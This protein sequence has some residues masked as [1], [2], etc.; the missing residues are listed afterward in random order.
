MDKIVGV[1]F[2]TE[3]QLKYYLIGNFN[4]NKNDKVIAET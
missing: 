3:S 2:D 1:K 4:V